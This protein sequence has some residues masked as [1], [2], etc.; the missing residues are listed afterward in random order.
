MMADGPLSLY[1]PAKTNLFLRITKKRDDGFHE[2]ASVF[3]ALGLGDTLEISRLPDS[4]TADA[5]SC[6]VAGVPLD[7]KNLIVQAF[8][9]FRS[10]TG[11]TVFFNCDIDKQTPMEGGM[12]GGS[13]NCAT[14]LWA[15][16]KLCGDAASDEDLM[17]WGGAL[18]SDVSF[19]LSEGTAYCTGRGEVIQNI[20]PPLSTPPGVF[21]I[22]KPAEGCSTP[23]VYKALGLEKGQALEGPDPV[24]L[25]DKMVKE[26]ISQSV[27]VNDLEPPAQAVL[28]K[29]RDIKQ[30]L[31]DGGFST[32]LLSGSGAT[33]FCHSTA[34]GAHP[35]KALEA[36]GLWED[37]MVVAGPL[38]FVSRKRGGWY[39]K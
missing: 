20:S 30:A 21:Y 18:G 14:A 23:A 19:F 36:K 2:L 38:P 6:N 4:A 35:R 3:Q 33:T 8:D 28:P 27:C 17:V 7:G 9:L 11:Q 29:L 22:L 26:G 12:G 25:R 37:S 16:N 31:M 1:S 39:S 13:S 24:A 10:K 32:V 5:L 15:A 34:A